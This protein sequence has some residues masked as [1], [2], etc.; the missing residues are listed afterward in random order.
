MTRARLAILVGRTGRGSNMMNLIRACQQGRIE[1]DV[2]LVVSPVAQNPASML[3]T[4][5]NIRVEV[6]DPKSPHYAQALLILLQSAEID[7]ICLA[8]YM[9]LLPTTILQHFP[10]RILN[11]HPALLPKHGGKGMYGH[12]V[13]Q[14]VLDSGETE[15]G[16]TIHYVTENYDEGEIL[17]QL[18]CPVMPNDTADILAARV[19]ELEH[20]AYIQG[21]NLALHAR[22]LAH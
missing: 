9:N 8:G 5:E 13:H 16:A 18:E 12:H 11:V 20:Q 17:V 22:A 2:C 21:V 14:S 19:L 1:G 10:N 3:A 15:T 4:S 7:M 6:L